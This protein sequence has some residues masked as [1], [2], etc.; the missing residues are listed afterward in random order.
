M[1]TITPILE[2]WA[3]IAEGRCGYFVPKKTTLPIH[4]GNGWNTHDTDQLETLLGPGYCV[5]N[6]NG[7]V[8]VDQTPEVST[9]VEPV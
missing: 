8:N 2:A 6:V 1:K 5:R 3:S 9:T 4:L 7:Y